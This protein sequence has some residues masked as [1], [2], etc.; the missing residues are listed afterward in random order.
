GLNPSLYGHFGQGCIHCRIAF[1]LYTAEGLRQ[2]QS[3]MNDA[4]DLVVRYGGSISGEHG[5]G[6]ARAE[7]LGKMFGPELVQAFG[8]FKGIWD[9]DGKM[10][11]GKVVDP[12]PIVSN[13]RIGPDYNPPQPETYFRYPHDR[14]S[15]ARAALRCVSVGLCRREGGGTMCPSYMVTRA[16]EH[17]T[18]G[19]AHLLFEMLNGE[20]ISDGWRSESVK[21]ALDLCLAC[22]GCKHDCPVGVD[23]ATYK[24][25]FLSHYYAGRL[26]P[27]SAYA[28]G[29]IPIWARLASVAPAAA[30][31][32]TQAP[33]LR[34]AS[35]WIAGVAP[36]RKVPAFAPESFTSWWRRRPRKRGGRPVLLWPDTFNNYFHPETARAAV[37][38][39]EDAGFRVVVPSQHLCCGR[40]L[41]DYGFLGMA[42]RWLLDIMDTLQPAIQAGVPIVVLEPSCAAVFRDEL[43]E[44]FPTVQDAHR[45]HDQT[46]LL[47]EFLTHHAPEYQLPRLE[48]H[49][50]V[51]GHCH[52]KSVMGMDDEENV[53]QGMAADYEIPATGCCG[54]AGSFGFEAGERY[55]VGAAA[56]ERELLP[57]VRQA[58]D[59]TVIIANGFSCR[60]QIRQGSG[61]RAMHLAEVLQLARHESASGPARGRP[62]RPLIRER[63]RAQFRSGL[64]AAGI[65]AGAVALGTFASR[66]L[67][68]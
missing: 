31:L 45:L 50:L 66:F 42:K 63:R 48:R 49:A 15:F 26:R 54:M 55:R 62:E 3:F 57:A 2:Y 25:E 14:H 29:W 41:Y 65:A 19:R 47:S 56:G 37:D 52:H 6:Q 32:F 20:V 58:S 35:K 60:E 51:H 64:R 24:A 36:E 5:D 7:F 59:D 30:N 8:E 1:D 34:D 61:R 21:G 68:D 40:P 18:R 27:R 9:P 33:L 16:E 43:I 53:L 22:K 46:Q 28:F 11:P 38:V 17:S 44:L 13:L 67:E 10:N 4:T 23:M 39:L 12:Y